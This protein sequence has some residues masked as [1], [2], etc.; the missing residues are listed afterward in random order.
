MSFFLIVTLVKIALVFAVFMT[1]LAYLQ[2][3]ERKVLAHIQSRTGPLRVG[4]HGLL[5]PLA[6]VFK[7]LTKE[8]L[9]P[10]HANKFFY[11]LAPFIAVSVGAGVHFDHSVRAG[12][13]GARR[14]DVHGDRQ[15]ER[16][17]FVYSGGRC[18]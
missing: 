1:T 2:W 13:A 10:P 7:L 5:Q 12:S 18:D 8:D 16:R 4:P 14:Q 15:F 9:M 3:V 11:L 17:H 6:D